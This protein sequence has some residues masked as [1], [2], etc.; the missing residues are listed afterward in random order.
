MKDYIFHKKLHNEETGQIQTP[1]SAVTDLK[2]K[3]LTE[4]SDFTMCNQQLEMKNVHTLPRL[5]WVHRTTSRL[6]WAASTRATNWS[7]H[8]PLWT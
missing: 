3:Y 4:I 6:L 1:M 8:H 2:A 7:H 5:I